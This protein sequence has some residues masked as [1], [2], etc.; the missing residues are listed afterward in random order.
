MSLTRAEW[1]KM[2]ESVKRIEYNCTDLFKH[3]K[4]NYLKDKVV[5]IEIET[6]NIKKQIE[7]VI[8]QME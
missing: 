6:A 4:S 3:T 1:C 5:S 8:G 2:W 7:S